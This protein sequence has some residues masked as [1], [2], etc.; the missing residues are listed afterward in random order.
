M[1]NNFLSHG[2]SMVEAIITLSVLSIL[3]S[4]GFISFQ[5]ANIKQSIDSI[6]D[7]L[8]SKLELAKTNSITGKGSQNY[9]LKFNPDSYIFFSGTSFVDNNP[10]NEESEVSDK[11]EIQTNIP[12]QSQS[13]IFSKIT[14]EINYDI[15]IVISIS[16]KNNPENKIDII[17][18][19]FGE[20]SMIK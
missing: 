12:N 3:L 10:E 11:F 18:G 6:A 13:V 5:N 9:G 2:F 8:V 7:N 19:K 14:G 1:K 16:E 4:I 15:E 17:I 20:I